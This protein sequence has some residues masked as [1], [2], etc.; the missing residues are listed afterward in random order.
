MSQS[1][2]PRFKHRVATKGLNAPEIMNDDQKNYNKNEPTSAT[3]HYEKS[4]KF[5]FLFP[6]KNSAEH[7]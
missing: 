2:R 3:V 6:A 1:R 5:Y 7:I 4:L